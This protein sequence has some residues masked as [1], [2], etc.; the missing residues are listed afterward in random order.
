MS[1]IYLLDTNTISEPVKLSPNKNVIEK[2]EQNYAQ[3]A[4]PVFVVYELLRGAYQL[5][6]SKKRV[7]VLHY[8]E[9]A[10]QHLPILPYTKS[11]A[12]WHGIE[13]ARLQGMG[14]SPPFID[15]QIAA[16]AI[17]NNLTLV[18]RNTGDFKNFAD[19]RLEN[20]FV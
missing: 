5:P 2:I 18:T 8:V 14:K 13:A 4:L 3:I 17:T 7:R 19:F 12:C 9:N 6:E 10:I 1:L 11:S 15:A 20:W 16:V